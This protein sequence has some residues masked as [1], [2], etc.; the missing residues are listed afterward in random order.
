M[1]STLPGEAVPA[2]P[3]PWSAEEIFSLAAGSQVNDRKPHQGATG[4]NPGLH[5]GATACNSTT[6]LGV[7]WRLSSGTMP[8]AT[9]TYE[10]DAFGN[11]INSTGTTP[12]NYLYRS[13]QYD[14]DLGMYYLRARYYNPLTGRFLS[15]DSQAGQ[16]QRRYEYAGADPVNS[17]DPSGNEAIIEFALLQFYPGRLNIFFPTWCQAVQGT[18]LAKYFPFCNQ[19]GGGSGGSG[20]GPAAPGGPPSPRC[21]TPADLSKQ[22]VLAVIFDTGGTSQEMNDKQL[23]PTGAYD[24]R[25]VNYSLEIAPPPGRELGTSAPFC[26]CAITE[27]Q[28]AT[29]LTVGDGTQTN[30]LFEDT[31]GPHAHRF[32]VIITRSHRFFTVVLD[33]ANLGEVPIID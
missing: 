16:G 23:A 26:K 21:K 14:P 13:E 3:M 18:F 31:I 19:R 25:A 7:S 10:Y 24:V 29:Q 30:G 28:S 20:A 33:G 1:L 4:Q 15:V 2:P 17:L 32:P 12:N 5:Q 27:H 22:Y 9:V 8:G 11:K 6:A